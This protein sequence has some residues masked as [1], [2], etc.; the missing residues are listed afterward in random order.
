MIIQELDRSKNLEILDPDLDI[1]GAETGHGPGLRRRGDCNQC[2]ALAS[3]H[4]V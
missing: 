2:P 1:G 3:V 4:I